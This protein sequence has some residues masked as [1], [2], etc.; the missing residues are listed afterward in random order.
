MDNVTAARIKS[1]GTVTV[2]CPD[3][4]KAG[5]SGV[6]SIDT[7]LPAIPKTCLP[8]QTGLLLDEPR[9]KA[10]HNRIVTEHFLGVFSQ[11][12]P[13][14]QHWTLQALNN[15]PGKPEKRQEQVIACILDHVQLDSSDIE[16]ERQ[17]SLAQEQEQEARRQAKAT[18]QQATEKLERLSKL[19]S[20]PI[21]NDLFDRPVQLM[22]DHTICLPCLYGSKAAN[23]IKDTIVMDDPRPD[24]VKCPMCRKRNV[25]IQTVQPLV[26]QTLN[27]LSPPKPMEETPSASWGHPTKRKQPA[28]NEPRPKRSHP[29]TSSHE[30]RRVLR[31][32]SH[33]S[34]P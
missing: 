18:E 9:W 11:Q 34:R 3:F 28:N 26:I 13:N 5:S 32:R 17:E 10:M 2:A 14:L 30:E 16:R 20:C 4:T 8:Y 21:C 22:C 27:I 25:Q 15:M 12:A 1:M 7:T 23:R 29:R 24:K 6:R 19:L 33:T 31:S